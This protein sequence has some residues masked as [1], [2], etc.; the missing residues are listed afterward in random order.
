MEQNKGLKK[1]KQ[2][3]DKASG[4]TTVLEVTRKIT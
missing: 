1:K 4:P 3:K 2:S